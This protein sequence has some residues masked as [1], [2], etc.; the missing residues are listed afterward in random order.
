MLWYGFIL[1]VLFFFTLYFFI[2]F[3]LR[4]L[5]NTTSDRSHIYLFIT[6]L[7]L[8]FFIFFSFIALINTYYVFD[9]FS[10]FVFLHNPS[11]ASIS[12]I[13]QISADFLFTLTAN[14]FNLLFIYYF[15]FTYIFV[16][17]TILSILFCL[18]YSIN[19]L[20]IFMFYCTVIL[21][22]GYILFFTD[23]LILFFIAYEMLLI[24]SFFILYKF[25][26]TR[27]CIEAA[28]LMFF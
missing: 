27:R 3:I 24:P 25:A 20:I 28:Y 4:I 2:V 16:L 15:P 10:H 14:N 9:L 6:K 22:A 18:A 17:I 11:D 19:E 1:Y 8:S 7:T 12:Y 13:D 23:S 5:Y 26:K 21:I